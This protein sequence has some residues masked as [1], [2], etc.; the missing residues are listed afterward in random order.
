[1]K[2]QVAA[3]VKVPE[4]LRGTVV[5]HRRRCGKPNCRCAGGE[6][7]HVRAVL[8]YSRSSRT[9]FL[10]LP[11]E[12]VEPVRQ[13]TQRYR[14]ARARLEAEGETGLVELVNSLTPRPGVKRRTPSRPPTRSTE[15]S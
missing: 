6:A 15:Q 11:Q 7:L 3:A 1:M 13:A 14:E 9:R 8:S 10:T 5:D 2:S 12:V 4:M